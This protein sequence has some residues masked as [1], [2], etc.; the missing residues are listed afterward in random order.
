MTEETRLNWSPTAKRLK[1]TAQY[2]PSIPE[3]QRFQQATPWGEFEM[4]VDNPAALAQLELG[5]S[6][7]FDITPADVATQEGAN[8]TQG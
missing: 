8:P 3:D 5:K 4:Q 1:F 2:D 6:Y 7:Y